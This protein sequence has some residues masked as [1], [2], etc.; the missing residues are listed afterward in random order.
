MPERQCVM[1]VD[2]GR[3]LRQPIEEY[4]GELAGLVGR[5]VWFETT[6]HL[7]ESSHVELASNH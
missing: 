2:L 4:G 7:G 3:R 5:Q 6:D 1:A